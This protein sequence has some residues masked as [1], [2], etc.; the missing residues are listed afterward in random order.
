MFRVDPDAWATIIAVFIACI[1]IFVT[2]ARKLER[3]VK[4]PSLYWLVSEIGACILAA[5]IA[6]DI[7]PAIH[8]LLPPWM[9]K[10]VFMALAIW[11][12]SKFVQKLESKI[13]L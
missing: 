11:M 1:S 5:M 2:I 8:G 12:G 13:K 4:R 6:Y 9:T 10:N 7:F 3:K